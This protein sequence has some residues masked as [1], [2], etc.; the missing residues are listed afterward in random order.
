MGTASMK[1]ILKNPTPPQN[2]TDHISSHPHDT[3]EQLRNTNPNLYNIIRA[4]VIRD[5]FGLCAYCECA[6]NPFDPLSTR[7]EHFHPKSDTSNPNLNWALLWENMI[8]VCNGGDNKYL[9]NY[10]PPLPANLSCDSHKNHAVQNGKLP[11]A[12]EGLILNP[13]EMIATPCLYRLNRANGFLEPDR[14]NCQNLTVQGNRFSNVFELVENTI[15]VLNLNCDRLAQQRLRVFW[16]IERNKQ[17]WRTS[18]MNVNA[19]L[20]SR[21]FDFQW[22]PFFTTIRLCLGQVAENH[23]QSIQFLG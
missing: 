7:V 12:C 21:Y 20:I 18:N 5:Q 1:S 14:D 10:L 3:W 23:L 11:E 19:N 13:L 17:Q 4:S 9:E 6:I 16:S 15:K 8:G 22:R 2:L